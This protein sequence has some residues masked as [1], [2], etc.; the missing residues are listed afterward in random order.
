MKI[1]IV[2]WIKERGSAVI[3]LI[4]LFLV[5]SIA[6]PEFMTITNLL[7]IGRQMSISMITAVGMTLIIITGGIHLAVGSVFALSGTL[8]AVLYSHAGLP[9]YIAIPI[10]ILSCYLLGSIIG[11]FVA[12]QDLP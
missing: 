4:I 3:G 6:S 11:W 7:N 5:L 2:N 12:T 8:L 10:V 9:I 1:S